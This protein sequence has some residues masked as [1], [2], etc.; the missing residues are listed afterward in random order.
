MA[1]IYARPRSKPTEDSESE[2]LDAS[3]PSHFAPSGAAADAFN[4][5]GLV[6]GDAAE[7]PDAGDVLVQGVER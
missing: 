5:D 4:P 3:L 6:A 2:V 1:F 7:N